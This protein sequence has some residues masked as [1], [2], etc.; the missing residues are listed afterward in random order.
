MIL[1]AQKA[2]VAFL[3]SRLGPMRGNP[4]TVDWTA[5]F[6]IVEEIILG[7]AWM[8]CSDHVLPGEYLF[9]CGI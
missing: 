7:A 9:N 2:S 6:R 5:M 1:P 3:S 4:R 8:G